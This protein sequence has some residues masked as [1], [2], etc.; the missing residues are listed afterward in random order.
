MS[1]PLAVVRNVQ[2]YGDYF[3]HNGNK[4]G[5]DRI[6][7]TKEKI[8]KEYTNGVCTYTE[9]DRGFGFVSLQD[10]LVD[11]D[12]SYGWGFV[13]WYS[14]FSRSR[15]RLYKLHSWL[16][17]KTKE[18]RF[19]NWKKEESDKGYFN[20]DKNV[21]FDFIGNIYYKGQLID[22]LRR[23]YLDGRITY[24]VKKVGL[25]MGVDLGHDDY[26]FLLV[27]DKHFRNIRFHVHLNKDIFDEYLEDML[28]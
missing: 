13:D 6:V 20:F 17:Q 9:H 11:V 15:E 16:V 27:N 22:N 26:M 21:G 3:I 19:S 10:R 24:G 4:I 18:T 14:W 2:Y 1:Q 25:I 7:Y 23:A 5:Y 8:K 12:L 28:Q